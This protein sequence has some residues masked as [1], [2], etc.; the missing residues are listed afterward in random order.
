MANM[1]TAL[2]MALSAGER[3]RRRFF[4]VRRRFYETLWAETAEAVGATVSRQGRRRLVFRRNGRLAMIDRSELMIDSACTKALLADKG[5]TYEIFQRKGVPLPPHVLIGPGDEDKAIRFLGDQGRVVVKPAADT[6]AGR[7][8]TTGI[9]GAEELIDAIRT[10]R[11]L[12]LR[13]LIEPHLQGSSYRL[14][15]LNGDFLQAVRRDPP[16]VFGDGRTTIGTLIK[17]ET[18]RR[19]TGSTV[20][21]LS[22]LQADSDC[23]LCLGSQGLS[24]TDRPAKGAEIRVKSVVNQNGAA[25]NHIVTEKI[26]PSIHDEASRLARDLKIGFAGLD[27]IATTLARPLSQT[28]GYISEINVNPGIHHH[29]LVANPAADEPLAKTILERVLTDGPGGVD[30]G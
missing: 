19:L 21:A 7:G 27:I 9:D 30:I 25:Q 22:P 15:F 14:T 2:R 12:S 4:A 17:E 3:E 20:T 29:H 13:V 23:R 5:L 24:L 6:G 10:A 28:G 26:H 1:P 8:V 11:K 18:R 16:V